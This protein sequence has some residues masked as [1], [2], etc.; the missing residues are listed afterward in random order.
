MTSY[1]TTSFIAVFLPATFLVY[2]LAPRRARGLVLLLASYAFLLIISRD[3]LFYLFV[4]TAVT[5]GVGLG[6]TALIH[7]RNTSIKEKRGKRSVIKRKYTRYMLA[8]LTLGLLV[9]FGMLIALR[10]LGFFGRIASFVMGLFGVQKEFQQPFFGSAMGISFYTLM[11]ASYLFDVYHE[12]IAA[13][14]NPLRVALYLSFFPQIMEGPIARYEQTASALWAGN[15]VSWDDVYAGVTRMTWGFAKK[16]IVADRLNMLVGTVFDDFQSYNGGLIAIAAVLYTI[17]LYCDFSGCMDVALGMGQLLGVQLPENFRQPFFSQTA[18][19]FWQRW[20][21]T[22]GAWLKDYVYYPIALSKPFKRLTMRARKTLGRR[23]GPLVTSGIALFSVWFLNGLWHG[24]GSQYLFFGMYYFVI[25]L[26]GG[27]VEPLAQELAVR[28]GINREAPA[29][30]A[31]RTARTLVIVFFG[32]LIFRADSMAAGLRMIEK[33]VLGFTL[34][35]LHDGSLLRLGLDEKDFG[36]IAIV[37]VAVLGYDLLKERGID[38][39][40]WLT[41]RPE[42]LRWAL[43]LLLFLCVVVFGAYGIGYVP[44]DPMYAQY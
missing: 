8:L 6:L 21:I 30:R 2:L 44:V 28:F 38:P 1:F 29:Y 16:L 35:P 40:V 26:L 13:D 24:A 18:S 41:K 20:H 25:I 14:R 22:L 43:W 33:I 15:D 31:F 19:E 3:T 7:A 9:L 4:A 23:F 11:A 27:F 34:A 10:Y 42:L 17:Q 36:I 32:E 39:L 5:Y 37:C 12:R